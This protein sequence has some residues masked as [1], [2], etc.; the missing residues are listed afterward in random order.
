MPEKVLFDVNVILDVLESREPHIAN[1]GPA[2][3]MAETGQIHGCL[4]ASSVDTLAFLIRRT[5]SSVMT[6]NILQELIN[7]LDVVPVDGNIIRI[8]LNARWDDPEDAILYYAA[9][10]AG[11][12][13]IV[14]RNVR[15]FKTDDDLV[16]VIPP[17]K[18]LES[19]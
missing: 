11:C 15:D 16:I 9:A 6:N 2:L 5:A 13:K 4:S 17:E 19:Q 1:S 14:T 12:K 8:A 18:L 3:R 7:I 10:Q